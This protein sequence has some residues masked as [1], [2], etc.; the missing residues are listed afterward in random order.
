MACSTRRLF[1]ERIWDGL[2]PPIDSG[3]EVKARGRT[4][5]AD[6]TGAGRRSAA[7]GADL[8]AYHRRAAWPAGPCPAVAAAGPLSMAT[9]RAAVPLVPVEGGRRAAG[10]RSGGS[11]RAGWRRGCPVR[12]APRWRPRQVALS[13]LRVPN[14]TQAADLPGS[15][16][17]LVAV[18]AASQACDPADALLDLRPPGRLNG[19]VFADTRI[20]RCECVA[21]THNLCTARK[22]I[23]LIA[24]LTPGL[25]TPQRLWCRTAYKLHLSSGTTGTLS[26][27]VRWRTATE[28][29]QSIYEADITPCPLSSRRR[30]SGCYGSFVRARAASSWPREPP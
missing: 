21:C 12:W 10:K 6:G 28:L 23:R 18:L 3:E 26:C 2:V 15:R 9:A 17:A 8:P 14:G 13:T 27:A 25:F 19:A 5:S 22:P 30:S 11:P 4:R 24:I 16:A 20:C 29:R 7:G 1:A